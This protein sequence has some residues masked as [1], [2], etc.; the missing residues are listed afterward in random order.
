MP[1]PAPA[2]PAMLKQPGAAA[3]PRGRGT[4]PRVPPGRARRGWQP[5]G[6]CQRCARDAAPGSLP[7]GRRRARYPRLIPWHSPVELVPSCRE[8]AWRGRAPFPAVPAFSP[9]DA[10][11]PRRHRGATAPQRGR[12]A[13]CGWSGARGSARSSRA[14]PA[15]AR[16]SGRVNGSGFTAQVTK[17]RVSITL[18]GGD[19]CLLHPALSEPTPR[20]LIPSE[21]SHS[22]FNAPIEVL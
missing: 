15:A 7:G 18:S 13:H 14:L 3:E 4:Q 9:W 8:P 17:S 19:H 10:R 12:C 21:V 5:H 20:F 11:R 6:R 2:G 22:S 16:T 1:S